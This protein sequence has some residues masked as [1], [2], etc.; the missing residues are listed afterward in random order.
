[1]INVKS[2]GISP[3]RICPLGGEGVQILGIT[4]KRGKKRI[5][6]IDPPFCLKNKVLHVFPTL[7]SYFKIFFGKDIEVTESN[8]LLMMP[9]DIGSHS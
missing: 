5:V 3:L 8:V 6:S 1:M 9:F 7:K 2:G 4:K